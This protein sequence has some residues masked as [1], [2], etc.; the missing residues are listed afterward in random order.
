MKGDAAEGMHLP[1]VHC[2]GHE[3]I[4]YGLSRKRRAVMIKYKSFLND[5]DIYHGHFLYVMTVR[6]CAFFREWKTAGSG[7]SQRTA[8]FHTI[9]G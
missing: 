1:E 7:A 4:S 3:R 2:L 6:L 9:T 5:H 8:D